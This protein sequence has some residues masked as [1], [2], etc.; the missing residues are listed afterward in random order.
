MVLRQV[1]QITGRFESAESS[2]SVQGVLTG[3]LA[4]GSFLA[5]IF[6]ATQARQANEPR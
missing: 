3:D 1:D 6:V 5:T 2:G 4:A